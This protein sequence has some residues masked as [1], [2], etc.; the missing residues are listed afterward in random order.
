MHERKVAVVTAGAGAGIGAAVVRQLAVDGMTVVVT[1]AHERRCGEHAKR[2]AE[3][4]SRP[5]LAITL[6]VTNYEAVAAAVAKV[7]AEFGRHHVQGYNAGW[8]KSKPVAEMSRDT[9]LNCLE[10]DLNGT[11]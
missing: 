5:F 7:I 11:F 1:D 9:W 8:S 4:F 2:L 6:D 10:V 3:E